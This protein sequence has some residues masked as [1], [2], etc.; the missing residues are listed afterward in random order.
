MWPTF[1]KSNISMREVFK[2]YDALS[3]FC[4]F[5]FMDNPLK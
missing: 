2:F 5:L 1:G 4:G 3:F